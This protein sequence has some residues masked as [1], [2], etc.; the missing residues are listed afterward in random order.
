MGA[1]YI[2]YQSSKMRFL[3]VV[4]M[5]AIVAAQACQNHEEFK[6]QPPGDYNRRPSSN[7]YA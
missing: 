7:P 4:V 2:H 5:L 1:F 3:T 6:G